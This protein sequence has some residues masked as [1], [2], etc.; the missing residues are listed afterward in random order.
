MSDSE[1]SFEGFEPMS[2]GEYDTTLYLIQE[3]CSVGLE[4]A[5]EMSICS[6]EDEE[7]LYIFC[8]TPNHVS[9]TSEDE[10]DLQSSG[11]E[12]KPSK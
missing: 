6:S 10:E 5:E 7:E 1:E 11:S 9:E 4:R 3:N 12:W 8:I 2:E